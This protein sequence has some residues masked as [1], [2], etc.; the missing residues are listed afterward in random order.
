MTPCEIIFHRINC[1]R[2]MERRAAERGMLLRRGDL[3]RLEALAQQMAPA[4]MRDDVTRVRFRIV[5][6]SRRFRVIYDT[7][8]QCLVTVLPKTRNQKKTRRHI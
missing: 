1:R 8:C 4:F 5:F 6:R 2:H 7:R 3:D